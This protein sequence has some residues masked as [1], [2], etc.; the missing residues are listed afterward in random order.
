MPS[1]APF[2]DPATVA[3]DTDQIIAEA[4]PL[5]KLAGVFVAVSLVPF[6]LGFFAGPSA[7]GAV[8]IALGQF[9]LA[10]GTG[11]V[12]MYVIARGLE[13]SES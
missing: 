1:S 11:I 3:L 6:G 5:A 2:V 12:L 4:F 13:L 9:V 7:L 8:L 10:V